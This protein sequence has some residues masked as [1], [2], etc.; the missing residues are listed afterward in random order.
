MLVTGCAAQRRADLPRPTKPIKLVT[1]LPLEATPAGSAQKRVPPDA[2]RAVTG[3]VYAALANRSDFRFVPD[4]SV[5][6]A[7]KAPN[8]AN[9]PS[10]EARAAEL[11]KA[12]SADAVIF[13]TV[14][15]FDERVG[16][17]YGATSPA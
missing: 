7:V 1:V 17:E 11:G 15:R 9:A 14:S 12:L 4:L 6:D 3:Q 13:G 2:G 16:T 5:E 10:L 8:I